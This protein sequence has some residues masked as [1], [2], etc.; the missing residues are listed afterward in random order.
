[1]PE[2]DPTKIKWVTVPT[3]DKQTE[4]AGCSDAAITLVNAQHQNMGTAKN[5]DTMAASKGSNI[6]RKPPASKGFQNIATTRLGGK[7]CYKCG[8]DGELH[9]EST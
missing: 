1:M 3:G 2:P 5:L 7:Q 6:I 9:R 4:S 8:T